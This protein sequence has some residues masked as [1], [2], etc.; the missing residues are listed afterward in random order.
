[1]YIFSVLKIEEN[2]KFSSQGKQLT[3]EAFRSSLSGLDKNNR[4]VK[5]GDTLPW[6]K[7]EALY[8]QSLHNG[9]RGAG[10]KPARMIIGALIIKN[11]LNLSNVETVQN[12]AENP[13][14]QYFVG[15]NEF[16]DRH[17]F[18][19]SLF[20]IIRRRIGSEEFETIS[21]PYM[22]KKI[23]EKEKQKRLLERQRQMAEKQLAVSE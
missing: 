23:K 2:M 4:W 16:T 22:K 11:K 10:N 20:V 8:N 9:R 18:N 21:I 17:I 5:W 12:I 19:A 13:Y 3:I 14:M 6:D 15:L 1:M 7:I